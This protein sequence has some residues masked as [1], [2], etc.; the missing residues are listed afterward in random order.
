MRL[1]L[2]LLIAAAFTFMLGAG[3]AR[4]LDDWIIA[5]LAGIGF[6]ASQYL[7]LREDARRRACVRRAR[8]AQR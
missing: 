8:D 7:L 4:E 3:T 2:A 6:G 5:A 1:F